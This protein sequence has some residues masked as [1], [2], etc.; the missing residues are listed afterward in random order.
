[1]ELMLPSS[2]S[3]TGWL[4]LEQGDLAGR[5][6]CFETSICPSPICQC[7][8]VT[9]RCSPELSPQASVPVCLEMDLEKCEIANFGK[10]KSDPASSTVAKAIA[11]E[12]SKA[13]WNKL[14]GFYLGAKRHLT[15]HADPDQI[16]AH[17]PPLGAQTWLLDDQHCVRANCSCQEAALSF[18]ELR[19]SAQRSGMAASRPCASGTRTILDKLNRF[20]GQRMDG[21]PGRVSSMR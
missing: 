18:F 1:M 14:W 9:L 10:L 20:Q 4:L 2:Q 15:E 16:D 5:R 3:A 17:F 12:I 19:P 21:G 7:E 6:Y 13:D 8:R 11:N